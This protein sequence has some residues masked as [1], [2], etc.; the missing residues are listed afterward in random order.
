MACLINSS[1][2]EVIYLLFHHRFGR[3]S[4][5]VDT[6]ISDPAI[7]RIHLVIEY[8]H[9]QWVAL[10]LSRNGLWINQSRVEQ[11]E[12][13]PLKVGDVIAFGETTASQFIFAD[14]APPADLLCQR[15]GPGNPINQSILLEEMNMLYDEQ[16][17]DAVIHW[18]NEGWFFESK[19]D[20]QFL[21]NYDWLTLMDD[22]EHPEPKEWQLTLADV[23]EHTAAIDETSSIGVLLKIYKHA[24]E[25]PARAYLVLGDTELDLE[26]RHHHDILL[27][28]TKQLH[29]DAVER[30]L[31][32]NDAGWIYMED[33]VNALGIPETL[34][35]I[36]IHRLRKQL[37]HVLSSYIDT[38]KLIVRRRGQLKIGFTQ[39]EV[40]QKNDLTLKVDI[41]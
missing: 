17:K 19:S 16:G 18:T 21:L 30:S 36:Q 39:I 7:S 14:D 4:S 28:L 6:L 9:G 5:A 33:L 10:D 20:K 23:P 40:Y 37:Q 22:P 15:D 41:A 8:Q 2:D 35:N 3:L 32:A 13:H 29:E 24:A 25:T 26:V 38:S 34:I 1:T 31:L 27:Y 12:R 11:H